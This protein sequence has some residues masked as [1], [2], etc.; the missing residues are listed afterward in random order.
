MLRE[1]QVTGNTSSLRVDERRAAILMGLTPAEVCALAS[2]AAMGQ[3]HNG[4]TVF[5]YD[6]LQRLSLMAARPRD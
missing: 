5:T 1:V 3:A 6:E 2:Q 4:S